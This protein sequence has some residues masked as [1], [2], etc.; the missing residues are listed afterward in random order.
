MSSDSQA[1]KAL[2]VS[3]VPTVDY[4]SAASATP[5]PAARAPGIRSVSTNS[6]GE[7]QARTESPAEK[8]VRLGQGKAAELRGEPLR[9][10][11]RAVMAGIYLSLIVMV[12]WALLQG[13]RTTPFG[14]VIGS[15]FFGVGLTVIVFTRTELF[16]SNCFYLTVS[17]WAGKTTVA[18]AFRILVASWFGNLLGALLMGGLFVGADVFAEMSS[19]HV[20]F[21]GALHK[22]HAA[23]GVLLWK[24]VLANF[25]VCLAIWVA[26]QLREELARLVAIVLV[27]FIFLYLGF[28]HSIANM[29]TFCFAVLGGGD[30]S[31][32]GVARNL[33]LTTLGNLMGGAILVGVATAYS[34]GLSNHSAAE[35]VRSRDSLLQ[36]IAVEDP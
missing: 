10:L 9:Y 16:T 25:V 24:G 17:T 35:R 19:E 27:V 7:D 23:A 31:L 30:L 18:D 20:L 12:Y 33:A 21:A 11:L 26:L 15:C 8:A 3:Y 6:V 36:Q 1:Q 13:L 22:A 4:G 34:E 14:K 5:L 2:R 29:G 32:L 28:E